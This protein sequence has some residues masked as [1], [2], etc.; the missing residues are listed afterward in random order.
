MEK[1]NIFFNRIRELTFFQR[2]FGWGKTRSLSYEAFSEFKELVR[3]LEVQRDQWNALNNEKIKL[4][5]EIEGQ[6][7]RLNQ[8]EK[9]L[10]E[11]EHQADRLSKNIE[12]QNRLITDLNRKVTRFETEEAGRTMEY[13][14][15]VSALNQAKEEANKE[16]TKLYEDRLK[17]K[18]EN[19]ERMKRTWSEHQTSVQQKIKLICEQHTIHYVEKVPFRGDPDNTI[20]ICG[21]YII[22]DAKSPANDDLS[23]FPK[24]IRTQT[25]SVKKYSSQ[26]NVKKDIFLVIPSN[27]VD[28]IGQFSYNMGAYNVFV[29][30]KDALEP[31]ILSLKKIE[32]YEF[33]DSLSP[34]E[35]DNICRIIGRFAH[36]TK[37]R[38]QIDQ[39]FAGEFLEL[40]SR[41]RNDLPEPIL[42]QVIEFEKAEKLNPPSD[43]RAKQL[44][45]RDLQEKKENINAEARM[46]NIEIPENFDD[47]KKLD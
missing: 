8:L 29:I 12:E 42:Q 31:V 18:E 13:Q 36:T 39:F 45:T 19:F 32:E 27:T 38:I 2:L 10:I 37:R 25:E 43:K 7:V 9:N 35:R 33:A 5:A 44:L 41:C 20:E 14:R 22:F 1:L 47:V 26:E 21:E 34:E 17:E 3:Q 16:K 40:L 28:S 24:Y 30:T 23:N 4:Q 46:R 11:K 6:Q 15:N